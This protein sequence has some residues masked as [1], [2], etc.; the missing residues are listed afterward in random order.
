M[1]VQMLDDAGNVNEECEAQE[2]MSIC[3]TDGCLFIPQACTVWTSGNGIRYA[4]CLECEAEEPYAKVV[5][6]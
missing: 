2:E 1:I 6:P 5:R 4:I 3:D